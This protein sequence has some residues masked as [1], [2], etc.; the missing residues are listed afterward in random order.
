MNTIL[1]RTNSVLPV[2]EDDNVKE[3]QANDEGRK[4]LSV[5]TSDNLQ[6]NAA[7]KRYS[8]PFS[9]A[10]QML[11]TVINYVNTAEMQNLAISYVATAGMAQIANSQFGF[12]AVSREVAPMML[13]AANNQTSLRF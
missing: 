1:T 3:L 13:E 8:S 11:K 10:L 2:K 9:Y 6:T 4:L 5:S 7:S 12:F